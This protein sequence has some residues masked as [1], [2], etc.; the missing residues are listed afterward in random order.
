MKVLRA[1]GGFFVKIGRWIRDTAWVQ[2]LLIVG[3]I[4]AIVFSIQPT[5]NW[6]ESMFDSGSKDVA[7]YNNFRLSL[8]G[9]E[10]EDSEAD[11]L[12]KY[13]QARADESATEEQINR[14]GDKFFIA[15]VQEDCV[16][17]ESA[18]YGFE[19]LQDNWDRNGYTIN[20]DSS[21]KLYTIFIDTENDDDVNLF[22]RYFYGNYGEVFETTSGTIQESYYYINNGGTSS[23][24]A[25]EVSNMESEETFVSPTTFLIDFSDDL[26]YR[27]EYGV[28][29][30]FFAVDGTAIGGGSATSPQAKARTLC[31]AWN[32]EGKFAKDW[33]E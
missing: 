22:Q 28:S 33:Q 26:S 2:P 18:Y 16:G 29:E 21:F 32:H 11:E 13:L 20:D 25:T 1:I 6:I 5:V 27:N 12:F 24:Y 31:D 19:Y 8:E 9:C 4:F 7:Y 14:Y 17:C 30:V 15:F 23:T 10:D 3:G